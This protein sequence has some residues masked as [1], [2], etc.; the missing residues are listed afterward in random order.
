MQPPYNTRHRRR[1]LICLGRKDWVLGVG[2]TVS[3]CDACMSATEV[4]DTEVA[5]A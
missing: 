3:G 5:F 2:L 1:S 4:R